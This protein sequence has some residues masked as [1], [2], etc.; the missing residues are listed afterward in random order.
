MTPI[1]LKTSLRHLLKHPWQVGL[2]ILGVALGVA[3][4]VS[5]DLANSS[6]K[7]AFA[8][9]TETIAG[10]ATHQI[11]GGPNGLDESVYRTVR[12]D[13]GIRQSAPVVEGY[14][15]AP[16][17][18]GLT[19]RILG[20]DPL[21][22]RPFRSI[23]SGST[24]SGALA[25]PADLFVKP[26]AALLSADTA[27][28]YGLRQGD[29]LRLR[30][31]PRVER[32]TLIALIEP[33]DEAARRALDGLL[34]ADI[35]SAQEWLGYTGKLSEIDLILPDGVA[36]Q[37]QADSIASALP[38]GAQLTRPALRTQ[39]IEQMTA[40]FELNLTALSLLALIVG[41]FL[42]YNTITFSVV[43]RRGLIGTLRCLGVTRRQIFAL[44]L[45]E[46]VLVGLVGA[47]A[48]LV[49]GVV[50]GRGLIGLVTQTINDLYFTVSVRGI[51]LSAGPLIKGFLLGLLTTLAAAAVPAFEATFTP[52][53]TVLRR[54]SYEDRARRVVP[55]AGA[56]GAGLLLLG[57][58]LLAVPSKSL[59]LS[60]AAL[61]A[62]TIGAAAITPLVTLL[63]M[64]VA[65]P[66]LGAAFGL[67]G[68]MAAR[69]VVATLSR[70]SVAIAALMI[71]VS[72]TIGVGLMVGSFR[73]TVVQWLDQ[74]LRADVYVSAPSFSGTRTDTPLPPDLVRL[75]SRATG[76]ERARLYRNVT[77]EGQFGP[78]IVVGIQVHEPDRA[79]FQFLEGDPA[80][81]WP[82]FAQGQALVSEPLAY[83]Y[84]LHPGD[85]V[86]LLTESGRRAFPVAGVYSDY[87]SDQGV[88]ML[89]L[90]TYQ[91]AWNDQSISS[92]GLYAAPG[93]DVDALVQR[94]RGLVG[95]EQVISI[96]SNRALRETSLEIFDRTFAIT[97]VLQLLATIVAFVGIL[98]AL[99]ALQLERARELGM[100][101]ANGLTPRQLW[102]VVLSQ[103]GLMGVT[104][105]LLAIPVGVMLAAVLV[106]VINKRSFGWTLLFRLDG[107]LFAQALL[108]SI[109]A[110]LL[111]GLY[112]AWRMGRTPPA[113]ALREE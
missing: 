69:D 46:A 34:I 49:L 35:A 43:Q 32:A 81:I 91:A 109:A 45:G 8:L 83:R 68:R 40:A 21:A 3:V 67:L 99:M 42:I 70:T 100:L 47:T 80:A 88:V 38:P 79:A 108:V 58:A 84:G 76:V 51:A 52:P 39:A 63:L 87:G 72:V 64:R 50:L 18:P 90:A 19:L 15:A 65:R 107:G 94:L 105:G 95:A 48:G 44:I 61:F 101:R 36:G 9:S 53:R 66:A 89:D 11:V 85:S 30:I 56:A 4:V 86:T 27:R 78:T 33:P 20:L 60:F 113:L 55:L 12:L 111:A 31:G 73:Q 62:M 7:R 24:G 82:G 57:L 5:I 96:R 92:L 22:D 75:L 25:S 54:S 97:T 16:D 106:F 74:T 2:A 6:A 112:P 104:A 110:A 17:H 29:E 37:A 1:L 93:V 98:A 41:M 26:G 59:V 23:G 77:V 14:A 103:T 102:G 71:A 28:A 13:L 10:R